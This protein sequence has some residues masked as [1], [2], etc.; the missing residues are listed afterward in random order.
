MVDQNSTTTLAFALLGLV[1]QKP[2]S[3][4]DLRKFF[5]ST[6]MT[7]FSDSPGAIYPALRRLERRGLIRGQVEAGKGRRERRLFQVTPRG[8]AEFRRWLLQSVTRNDVVHHPD[9]LM[10]RFAFMDESMGR[11]TALRFLKAFHKELAS[12]I[13]TLHQYLKANRSAMPLSGRLALESGIL[14]YETL[15][16]WTEAAIAAY[17]KEN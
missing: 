9:A 12:Y 6:P 7:S 1:S 10:L 13:P 2:C 14:G 16:H 3:G 5:S 11:A 17:Q 4:Y 8:Q 15:F